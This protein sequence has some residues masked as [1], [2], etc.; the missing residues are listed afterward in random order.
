MSE[1]LVKANPELILVR[2]HYHDPLWGE[3]A[4]WWTKDANGVINDP[5][6]R[7][8]PSKGTGYYVEFDGMVSC[9]ECGK[10]MREEDADLEGRYAFCSDSCHMRFVGL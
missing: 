2:G 5:T 7:Q 9:A 1:A 6:A 3:Q 10:E 8:F 4:H